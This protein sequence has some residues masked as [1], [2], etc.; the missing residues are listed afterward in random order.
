M[1][2]R[3]MSSIVLMYRI[4]SAMQMKIVPKKKKKDFNREGRTEPDMDTQRAQHMYFI[5]S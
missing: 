4:Y 3:R 5:L 1:I 2:K